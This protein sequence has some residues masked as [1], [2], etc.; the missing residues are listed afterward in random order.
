MKKFLKF[1]EGAAMP[2]GVI[3]WA[4]IYNLLSKVVLHRE[5]NIWIGLGLLVFQFTGLGFQIGFAVRSYLQLRK[6]KKQMK[7]MNL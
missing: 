1:M 5:G 2:M 4:L 7:D 3:P 6:L